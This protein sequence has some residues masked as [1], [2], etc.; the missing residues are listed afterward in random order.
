MTKKREDVDMTT[1]VHQ[2]FN[3]WLE[4]NSLPGMMADS[5]EGLTP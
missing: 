2:A 1:I 5:L 3:S 4:A